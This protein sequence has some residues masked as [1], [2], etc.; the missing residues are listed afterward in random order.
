MDKKINDKAEYFKNEYGQFSLNGYEYLIKD[1]NTPLP[2]QHII[3]NEN[4]GSVITNKGSSYTYYLNSRENKLTEWYNDI[5]LNRS[6]E[7]FDGIFDNL[8]YEVRYGF[9]YAIINRDEK[10]KAT[11]ITSE[12]KIFIPEKDNIKINNIILKNIGKAKY[13][14]EINYTIE[15][16]LGNSRELSMKL[17][18]RIERVCGIDVCIISN[19]LNREFEG[20]EMFLF[21]NGKGEIK[22]KDGKVI[23]C[24]KISIDANESYKF[25]IILGASKKENEYI[26]IIEKY[27][28]EN[29]I[30]KEFENTKRYWSDMVIPKKKII[31]ENSLLNI[32]LNGWLM[33][34]TIACRIYSKASN[35][36]CGGAY[37]FRDQLQDCMCICDN[38]PKLA[39]NQILKNC[40]KQ[41][42][43]GDVLHWWHEPSGKGIRN[44][45]GDDPLWL[46][47]CTYEYIVVTGDYQILDEIVSYL[48]EGENLTEYDIYKESDF[49]ESVCNHC[50]RAIEYII[51]EKDKYG[52]VNI[53][54]GDWN[55]GLNNIR[56]SSVW[57]TIFA[58]DVLN[59]WIEL[60]SFKKDTKTIISFTKQVKKMKKSLIKN[61]FNN[62]YFIRIIDNDGKRLGDIGSECE[63]D[64]LPQVWSAIALNKDV[65]MRDYIISSIK[66]VEDKLIDKEKKIVKLLSPPF[67]NNI[68]DVGY[69]KKYV[70]GTRENGGQYNHSVVWLI[71]AYHILGREEEAKEIINWLLPD[72]RGIHE[73]KGE[74]Y[75]IASDIYTN[76]ENIGRCRMVI[77]YWCFSL[78]I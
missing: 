24:E 70:P 75:I 16:V 42:V 30:E 26:D 59:K 32:F 62:S 74:P 18:Y 25:S 71:F 66:S 57:L 55:D 43:E 51:N 45:Y 28:S 13:V 3:A 33:Y 60:A 19:K 22:V 17:E 6:G 31:T 69:I 23:L 50:L 1:N 56:G 40:S 36:Q 35:Y 14:K 53:K 37:G 39:K 44:K 7:F 76:D 63:I 27:I 67:N 21:S 58:I 72:A 64:L 15:P 9:G 52:L 65:F 73:Y 5:Y 2:W 29:S 78:A 68:I 4:F 11:H 20:T 12:L 38:H 10:E 41:F 46:A 77:L 49:S 34:Q 54:N 47:Y 8:N 48:D 61:G